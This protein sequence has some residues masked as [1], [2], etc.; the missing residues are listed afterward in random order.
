MRT[1]QTFRV[2]VF[3]IAISPLVCFAQD[4]TPSRDGAAQSGHGLMGEFLVGCPIFPG[5]RDKARTIAGMEHIARQGELYFNPHT[6]G[7]T[8][9]G[10]MRGQ[11]RPRDSSAR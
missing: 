7:Q 9:Y 1:R 2:V 6:Y 10:Y 11:L 3:L 8:Y 5:L 4:A